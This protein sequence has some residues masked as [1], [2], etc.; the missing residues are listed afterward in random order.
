MGYASHPDSGLAMAMRRR[1]SFETKTR[2][3]LRDEISSKSRLF[4]SG[5]GV[6][7]ALGGMFAPRC[8]RKAEM[9]GFAPRLTF[10]RR[11]HRL[12]P[13]RGPFPELARHAPNKER[14]KP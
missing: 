12:S 10:A 11:E 13:E 6:E 3:E 2:R 4:R 8:Q 9:S 1:D 14:G 7:R 5:F